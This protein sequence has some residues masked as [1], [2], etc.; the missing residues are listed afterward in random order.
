M[1]KVIEN[2]R[3]F[4]DFTFVKVVPERMKG[5]MNEMA[6]F[7]IINIKIRGLKKNYSCN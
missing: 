3:A 2:D 6:F 5:I 1:E 4:Q 7:P